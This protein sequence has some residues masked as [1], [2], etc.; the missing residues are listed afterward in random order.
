[1]EDLTRDQ[2]LHRQQSENIALREEQ[3]RIA[4]GE[5]EDDLIPANM[6]EKFKIRR[7]EE[8]FVHVRIATKTLN[9]REKRFDTVEKVD[10]YHERTFDQMVNQGA[11]GLFDEV[12]VIHHP[13]NKE[14][15]KE[16]LKP[17]NLDIDKKTVDVVGTPLKDKQLAKKQ[18][19]L[20][21]KIKAIDEQTAQRNEAWETAQKQMKQQQEENEKKSR[22]LDELLAKARAQTNGGE[23]QGK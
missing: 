18:A 10:V 7:L 16:Q 22:E 15:T 17:N 5:A 20:D 9:D 19:E 23:G 1:M 21:N 12:E 3:K 6:N 11:F 2:K 14:Y 13:K 8:N 4:N